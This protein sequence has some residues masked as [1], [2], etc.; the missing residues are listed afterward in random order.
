MN[1]STKILVGGLALAALVLG[2]GLLNV[3][4]LERRI[5]DLEAA[6][7]HQNAKD[8]L[9]GS[10]DEWALAPMVCDS[11]ELYFS[12]VVGI[13]ADIKKARRDWQEAGSWSA[14]IAVTIAILSVIPWLWYFLLRRLAEILEAIRGKPPT[15]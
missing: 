14:S 4:R 8:K 10:T 5:S 9:P 7:E 12:D 1:G 13:Q 3:Y 2:V 11:S 15:D 6:C